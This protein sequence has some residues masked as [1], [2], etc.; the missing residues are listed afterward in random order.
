MSAKLL[1]LAGLLAAGGGL[2][3]FL[4]KTPPQSQ[5]GPPLTPEAK[6]YVRSLGL[7]GVEMKATANAIGGQVVEITGNIQNKGDRSLRS[8]FI[9]CIFHDAYGQVVLK[10]RLEIVKQKLGGLQPGEMKSFRL[11][12]D[13]IPE[14]WNQGMPQL[15]IANIQFG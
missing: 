2:F 14:S 11:P 5:S 3:W 4:E 7:G 8:V 6:A 12:F 1:V 15:V 13:S 9:F 10:E